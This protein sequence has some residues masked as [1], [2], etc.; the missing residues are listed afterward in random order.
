MNLY[1]L[2]IVHEIPYDEDVR[3]GIVYVESGEYPSV[4]TF[5]C[6]CGC[7]SNLRLPLKIPSPRWTVTEGEGGT[8]TIAPSVNRLGDCKSHFTITNGIVTMH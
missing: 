2:H 4:C 7:D 5:R 6:P 8:A 1:F 3:P